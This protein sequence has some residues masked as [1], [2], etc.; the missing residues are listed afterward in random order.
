MCPV[1]K[2]ADRPE[3]GVVYD[4]MHPFRDGETLAETMVQLQGLI[5]H[6]HFHDALN[7]RKKVVVTPMGKGQLPVDEI[8][9]A[10]IKS[11]YNEYLSGEWFHDMYGSEPEE[12][13]GLYMQE[14]S[15]MLS[16]REIRPGTRR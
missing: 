8:L 9:D 11:G 5:R 15:E 12:A 14:I 1:I 6:V 4:I 10:L 2:L 3:L 13:L 16:K 7:D